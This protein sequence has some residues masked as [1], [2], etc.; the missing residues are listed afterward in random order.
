MTD[1]PWVAVKDVCQQYGVTFETAKNKIHMG[2]FPVP[3]FKV[4]KIWAIDR[5]VHHEYFRQIRASGLS[6]LKSTS[7]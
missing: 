3:T 7:R 2:T 5:E 4:G 1:M 6:A